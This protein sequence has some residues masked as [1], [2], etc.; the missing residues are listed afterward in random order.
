MFVCDIYIFRA[1]AEK[2]NRY[3]ISSFCLWGHFPEIDWNIEAEA[4]MVTIEPIHTQGTLSGCTRGK[5]NTHTDTHKTAVFTY[6][7]VIPSMDLKCVY[8]GNIRI[9]DLVL[10]LNMTGEWHGPNTHTH[11]YPEEQS[12]SF[13]WSL[14]HSPPMM[15]SS[16]TRD[17]SCTVSG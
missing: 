10:R 8:W 16:K 14:H 6:R 3:Q 11:N 5:S 1:A 15:L 17:S 12:H 2:G 4:H 7:Y 9:K 13:S